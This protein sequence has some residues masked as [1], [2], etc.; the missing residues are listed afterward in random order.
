MMSRRRWGVVVAAAVVAVVAIGASVTAAAQEDPTVEIGAVAV[1]Q[2]RLSSPTASSSARQQQ[3][4]ALERL[5]GTLTMLG[6]DPEDFYI[7]PI[8]LEFG[9]EAWVMTAGPSEDFDGDGNLERLL[10]ELRGLVG[11]PVTALVRLDNDGDEA[12]VYRLNDLTFR[13]SAGG[14]PPWL[15]ADADDADAATWE[16]VRTA[17]ADAVGPGA[18]VDEL[19]WQSAGDVAWE[20]DV[21]SAEGREHTVLLDSA[22]QVLD[23]RLG[24]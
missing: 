4:E 8:E 24:D 5:D 13:D 2:V 6:D 3:V 17:A 23:V 1:D 12:N 14:R 11:R 21:L 10:N 20:V 9:P 22:A 18:V 19:E 7:G 15:A 16:A